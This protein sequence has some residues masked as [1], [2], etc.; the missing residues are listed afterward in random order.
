M[1]RIL[2]ILYVATF[3][4]HLHMEYISF[5]WYNIPQLMISL[6]EDCSLQGRDWTKSLK[7]LSW[8]HQFESITADTM[9][10]LIITQYLHHKWPRIGFVRR[11][12]NYFFSSFT[13]YHRFCSKNNSTGTTSGAGNPNPSEASEFT[14]DFCEIEVVQSLI[15]CVVF[16]RSLFVLISFSFWTLYWLSSSIYVLFTCWALGE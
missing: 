13:T 15:F 9:N 12:H 7:S 1:E 5:S 6:I 8:S 11:N 16:C 14:P 3:Q 4:Q 10:W 2:T